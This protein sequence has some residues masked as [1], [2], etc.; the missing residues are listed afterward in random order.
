MDKKFLHQKY[1][2]E[3]LGINEIAEITKTS[4][5]SVLKKLKQ[6]EIQTRKKGDA[7]RRKKG[8]G[9]AY[10][11]N[12]LNRELVTN[13]KEREVIEKMIALKKTGFSYHKIAAFLNEWLIPT[14]TQ[15][16]KWHAK[17]VH[18]ILKRDKRNSFSDLLHEL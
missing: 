14:K 8:C 5:D 10:G 15:K 4:K 7:M 16:G 18:Q 13:E 3:R 9:L 11:S 6:F 1:C 12:V 17:T 2:I